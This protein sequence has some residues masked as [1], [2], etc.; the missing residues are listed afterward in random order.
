MPSMDDLFR[1]N[2][3]ALTQF[4][5]MEDYV[6]GFIECEEV[7]GKNFILSRLVSVSVHFMHVCG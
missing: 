5:I 4:E 1:A 3:E 6:P 2:V 7:Y